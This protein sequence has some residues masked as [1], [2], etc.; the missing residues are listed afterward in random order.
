MNAYLIDT[1]L[2]YPI[3]VNEFLSK[4]HT[5]GCVLIAS[6]TGVKQNYYASFA[7]FLTENNYSVYT[8]DY[9]GIGDSL[10]VP[11]QQFNTSASN[12]AKNDFESVIQHIKSKHSEI[13]FFLITHS[14]GGQLL[15]LIPSNHLFNGIILVA[16]QSGSYKHFTGKNKL[17]MLF[18]WHLYLPISVKLFNYLP[19]KKLIDMENLPKEMA[20]EWSKWCKSSNY[21]FDHIYNIQENYNRINCN[22]ISY[23]VE[24]DFF[25]PAKAVDWLASKYEKAKV[26]RKHL[27]NKDFGK[28]PIGHFGFFRKKYQDSIWQ[29]FLNDLRSFSK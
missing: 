12:W 8:F 15:G 1:P 4:T 23:S 22:L 7:T 25:A 21:H 26:T 14:I 6:A 11:L 24:N 13:N 17:I 9:G 3:A 10:K 16:S 29:L 5:N 19:S 27:L 18:F 20:I 2:G 28:K